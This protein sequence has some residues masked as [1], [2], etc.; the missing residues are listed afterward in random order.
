VKADRP[1]LRAVSLWCSSVRSGFYKHHLQKLGYVWPELVIVVKL[2]TCS[3]PSN[4]SCYQIV[5]PT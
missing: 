3:A 4:L 2:V 1:V 5:L